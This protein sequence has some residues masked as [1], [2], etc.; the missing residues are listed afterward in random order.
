MAISLFQTDEWE[1]WEAEVQ[2]DAKLTSLMQEFLVNSKAHDDY[3]LKNGRLFYQGKLVLPKK[4]S[5]IPFIIKE[6]HES[7]L[8]GHN[9]YFRTFKRVV[10]VVYR[11]GM[12]RDVKEFVMQ[13]DVYQRNKTKN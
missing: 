1:A 10:G 11:E 8:G 13:C 12:R 3:K 6:Q 7:P 4:Y 2:Q 9:G 5:H